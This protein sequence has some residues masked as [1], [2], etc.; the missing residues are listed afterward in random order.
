MW[1]DSVMFNGQ[2]C[3]VTGGT[4]SWGH[5]LIK[6]LILEGAKEIRVFSRNEYSQIKMHREFK[7]S[8]KIR[9]IIGDVRDSKA[10]DRACERVDYVFHLAALK[11]VP[12]CELQPTE[13]LMTNVL[14]TQNV[15]N[16]SLAHGVQKVIEVSTDKAVDAT[17]VYGITKAMGEHMMIQANSMDK[18]TRFV[19]IRGGNVLGTNGSIVPLFQQCILNGQDVPITSREMTRFFLNISE[20]IDLL[21]Q[22][23][24]AAV[25][26]ETFVM[27]MRQCRI[28]DLAEVLIQYL[29]TKPILL[30]EIGIRPGERLHEVLI[31]EYESTRTY[32]FDSKYY[33]ILP[34][35][36][37]EE[38]IQSYISYP[39]VSFTRYVSN[40]GLMDKEEIAELLR[41]GGFL[42]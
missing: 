25:G 24:K 22:A 1:G 21:I 2:I 34:T 41:T 9:F 6:R 12:V 26:G 19:C 32:E 27:K 18:T 28:V 17:N 35:A 13:A 10:V 20:A 30:R 33:V 31:S 37:S 38:L 39:K 29:S 15:I 36:P 40:E 42:T 14:G 4:G 5:E 3:L 11:H 16:S 7:N 8:P 23:A